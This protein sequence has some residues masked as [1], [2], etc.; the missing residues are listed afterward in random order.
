VIDAEY[1]DVEGRG[2][3]RALSLAYDADAIL[4]RLE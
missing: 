2:R 3:S 1:A 4:D